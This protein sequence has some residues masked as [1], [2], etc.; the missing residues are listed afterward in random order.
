MNISNGRLNLIDTVRGITILSMIGFHACWDLYYFGLGITLDDLNSTPFHIWQQ[1]ICWTFIFISGYCFLL[2]HHHIKRSAMCLGGGILI[3]V[4]TG[5]FVQ[6]QIDIF[7]VLWLLGISGFITILWDKVYIYLFKNRKLFAVLGFISCVFLFVLFRNVNEGFLGFE[8][9]NLI[10]LPKE[11]YNGYF[12][13]LLGFMMPGFYS[14]DYFSIIPWFFLYLAG[15]YTRRILE[16]SSFEKN[17]LSLN[18]KPFGL[19][20]KIGRH[21]LIIYLLHQVVLFAIFYGIN[22]VF[23]K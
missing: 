19:M 22:I 10:R 1:S 7:G 6:D 23:K 13:T 15:Y 12:M 16:N 14:S 20:N 3:T 4:I 17:V 9:W 18:I 5:I 2:G 11:L 8:G 21:S